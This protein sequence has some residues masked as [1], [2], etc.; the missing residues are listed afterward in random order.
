VHVNRVLRSLREDAMLRVERHSVAILD[1][2]RIRELAEFNPLYLHQDREP[3][4]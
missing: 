3:P 4:T 1:W 2:E